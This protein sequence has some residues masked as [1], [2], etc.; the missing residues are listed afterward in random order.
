MLDKMWEVKPCPCSPPVKMECPYAIIP[1][2]AMSQG[3][4]EKTLALHIVDLHNRWL[5][6]YC[7][8]CGNLHPASYCPNK[9]KK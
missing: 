6:E 9:E 1:G 5:E 2:V 4:L 8:Q 7:H 3:I